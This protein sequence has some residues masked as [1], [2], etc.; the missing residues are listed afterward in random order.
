[1]P[2]VGSIGFELLNAFMMSL[3]GEKLRGYEPLPFGYTKQIVFRIIGKQSRWSKIL[4]KKG[5]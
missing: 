4:T 3:V 2:P 1:M 5:K